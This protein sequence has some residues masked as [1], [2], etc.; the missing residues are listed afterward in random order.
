M[1]LTAKQIENRRKGIGGSDANTIMWGDAAQW[2]ALYE[3]KV[4][5]VQPVFPQSRMDLMEMGHAME[6]LTL[7]WFAREHHPLKPIP[8]DHVI[9][10][11]VD[12]FFF[13][14]PDGITQGGIPVQAKF[15][16]GD[17]NI[18]DLAEMY[19]AQL[20]HEMLCAN[21]SQCFLAV[22]FGHYGRRQHL[23]VDQDTTALEVYL[24]RAMAFKH[25][26]QTGRSP[27]GWSSRCR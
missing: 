1:A 20:A 15:H 6:P 3:E 23:P 8:A 21:T 18:L 10:W 26:M 7:K 11:Q 17:R 25:Y 12:P 22:T 19:A 9:E 13:F 2:K 5:G 24:Q 27:S 4:N 16:T 14:T